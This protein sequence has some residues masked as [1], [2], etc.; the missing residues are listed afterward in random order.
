VSVSHTQSSMP[1]FIM[2]LRYCSVEL[3]A[4]TWTGDR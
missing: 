4:H 3:F 1:Q 2:S